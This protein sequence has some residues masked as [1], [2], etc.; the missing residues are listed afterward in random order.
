M[1][2]RSI[3]VRVWKDETIEVDQAIATSDWVLISLSPSP[4]SWHKSL[5]ED[6]HDL[7]D[8]MIKFLTVSLLWSPFETSFTRR[9]AYGLWLEKRLIQPLFPAN[10]EILRKAANNLADILLTTLKSGARDEN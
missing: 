4:L 1:I 7:A 5:I 2:F 6:R 10:L 8:A 3:L 9:R